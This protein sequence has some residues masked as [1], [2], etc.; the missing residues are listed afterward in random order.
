MFT[1]AAAHRAGPAGR[2]ISVEAD[3]FLAS[4]LQ[5]TVLHPRN[6]DLSIS[7]LCAA[8]SSMSG[9]ARFNVAARGRSS[10]SLEQAG[11]RVSAGGVRYVQTVPAVTL[12][13][14]LTEFARP[15]LV[16]I[17][18]EGAEAMVLE[19]GSRLLTD[20]RPVLYVEVGERQRLQV[21]E[22]LRRHRYKLFDGDSTDACEL[23]VC[24]WNTLAVP[25][26]SPL[27]NTGFMHAAP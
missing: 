19:G 22:I 20:H 9:L 18:V 13:Q 15:D 14:L 12:D 26:E 2:V 11:A 16:K 7:V 10:N 4:I 25:Q 6:Q 17:D 21:G 1:L 8:V 5:Q 3:P 23:D 27:T 24:A